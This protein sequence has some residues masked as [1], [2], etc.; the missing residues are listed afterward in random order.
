[1]GV[2]RFQALT[3]TSNDDA[4]DLLLRLGFMS[5]GVMRRYWDGTED[6]IVYSMLRAECKWLRKENGQE[7]S[8]A[9]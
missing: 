9:A 6:A 8:K 5:E 7:R 1:M 3:K 2:D 4:Q